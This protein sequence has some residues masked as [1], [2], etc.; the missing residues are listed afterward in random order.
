MSRDRRGADPWP[1]REPEINES[2]PSWSA[3]TDTGSMTPSPEALTWQRRADAW[4]QQGDQQGDLEPYSGGGGGQAIEPANRWS[5]V[6]ATGRPTFPADGAGWR[7][8]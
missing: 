7:T 8:Q 5:D 4:A 3:L 1:T 2:E 6:A